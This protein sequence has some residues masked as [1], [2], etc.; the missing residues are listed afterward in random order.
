MGLQN[1]KQKS[2]ITYLKRRMLKK[3]SVFFGDAITDYNAA[4][5]G[6]IPF[7]GIR[8][9]HNISQ[10]DFNNKKFQRF[11]VINLNEN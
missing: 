11:I 10:R 4:L 9:S 3:I 1:Q 8:N 6:K 5:G 2:L 7:I